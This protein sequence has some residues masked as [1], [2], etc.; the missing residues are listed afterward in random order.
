MGWSG[1]CTGPGLTCTLTMDRDHAASA[2]FS[3]QSFALAVRKAGKGVG[4]VTSGPAGINCG[5][6]CSEAYA[7]G[8]RVVLTAEPD[9]H[10]ALA[11]W[12]GSCREPATDPPASTCTVDIRQAEDITVL[13]DHVFPW[14]MFLPAITTGGN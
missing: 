7:Y 13:F 2:L 12:Q 3:L 1:D 8:S 5:G 11:G 14:P 4:T 9:S 10:P 6:D